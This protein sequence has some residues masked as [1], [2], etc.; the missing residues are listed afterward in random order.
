MKTLIRMSMVSVCLM[1]T[2]C[3]TNNVSEPEPDEK[4]ELVKQKESEVIEVET[5]VSFPFEQVTL[6]TTMEELMSYPKGT[7]SHLQKDQVEEITNAVAD[8]PV[9]T[10]EQVSNEAFVR[11]YA[12]EVASRFQKQYT[13]PEEVV[14]KWKELAFG[15]D[16]VED[17][18]YQFKQNMNIY[19]LMYTEKDLEEEQARKQLKEEIQPFLTSLPP[20]VNVGFRIYSR[21]P[22]NEE[23]SCEYREALYDIKPYDEERFEQALNTTKTNEHISMKASIQEV[24]HD[25][26]AFDDASYTN[27]LH[28]FSDEADGCLTKPSLVA[29]DVQSFTIKPIV[30]IIEM[31]ESAR[32]KLLADT[33]D[34][35]YTIIDDDQLS[36]EFN[37]TKELIRKWQDRHLGKE[38]AMK[39]EYA[40]RSNYIL[41]WR[42]EWH[43]LLQEQLLVTRKAFE[44]LEQENKITLS[45][46]L[47]MVNLN[48]DY[49]SALYKLRDEAINHLF[50]VKD[51]RYEEAEKVI[52][53]TYNVTITPT[54]ES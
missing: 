32:L 1:I 50:S 27:I 3:S 53:E 40:E 28:V 13:G 34:G 22:S 14:Q 41:D 52:E 19:L 15:T 26:Q 9:L 46:Y 10:E 11:A 18:R 38:Q 20:S 31:E 25:F 48:R 29:E 17:E 7:Y 24:Y 39:S 37:R 5:S 2:A 54:E 4:P 23:T 36:E 51:E 42:L 30:H 12:D 49:I 6:P 33:L 47:Q 21:V 8:M 45:T 35:S 44:V 43:D 16:N